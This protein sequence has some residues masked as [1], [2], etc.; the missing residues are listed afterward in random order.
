MR[1]RPSNH[2][3][4]IT[5]VLA[6]IGTPD[7]EARKR[8]RFWGGDELNIACNPAVGERCQEAADLYYAG[9]MPFIAVLARIA[10]HIDRL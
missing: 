10:E 1:T 9:Q 5:P 3:S 6:F 4:P 8:Q 2:G 7:Y